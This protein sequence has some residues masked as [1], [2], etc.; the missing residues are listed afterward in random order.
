MEWIILKNA[1]SCTFVSFFCKHAKN[2]YSD[3]SSVH[4][5]K[6]YYNRHKN[7]TS[8]N[9]DTDIIRALADK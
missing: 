9:A 4:N 8:Q 7:C 2:T 6:Q 3:K 5:Q 1:N